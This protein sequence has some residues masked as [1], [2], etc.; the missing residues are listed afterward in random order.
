MKRRFTLIV[1]LLGTWLSSFAA[2]IPAGQTLYLYVSPYW[3]CYASYLFMTSHDNNK[4]EVMEAV[5]GQ[6][7]LYKFTFTSEFRWKLYFGA[8]NEIMTQG[9]HEWI[10]NITDIHTQQE[11][12]LNWTATNNCYIIDDITGSGH[13]KC[14]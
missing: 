2:N 7:G 9:G 6:P 12:N 3:S 10:A 14:F 5:Q 11:I 8:S 13:W 4:Y 1:L